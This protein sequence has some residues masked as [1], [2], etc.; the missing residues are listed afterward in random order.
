M[1]TTTLT[2]LAILKV[3]VD[4]GQDYLEYLR[5]FV[6]QVLVDNCT[7]RVSVESVT[8]EIGE[9]FGLSIPPR[10][11]EIVLKRICKSGLLKRDHNAYVVLGDLP[12][13]RLTLRQAEAQ[14]HIDSVLRGLCAFSHD[15]PN[16]VL[17]DE[18]AVAAVSAFLG[19]FDI[20]C[21]RAQLRGTAIPEVP[22]AN[23]RRILLVS[24]YVRHLQRSDPER[25]E[26]FLVL[27]K[28][29]MLAN[30]LTCPDLD[31]A[32]ASYGRLTFYL[33]TPLLIRYLGLEDGA[34]KT[35]VQELLDLIRSL[36]GKVAAFSHTVDEVRSVV[37]GSAQYLEIG[38]GR[39]SSIVL[40]A[41]KRGTSRSDLLLLANTVEERLQRLGVEIRTTPAYG[42]AFQID[43]TAFE[44]VL[45]RE[46]LYVNQRAKE[47]DIN[48]RAEHL[49]LERRQGDGFAREL[50][51]GP[52]NEQRAASEG[53]E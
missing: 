38:E 30:A 53:G 42:K 33:D 34:R 18:Q 35:A 41:R 43:E 29:N 37:R 17:D 5:P 51:G 10:T 12:D 19:T 7:L 39:P 50:A 11:V 3:N 23:G 21:L 49:R 20:S 24:D 1:T 8:G 26:S 25:F 14:R 15:T 52:R 2:S 9:Q 22:G 27:V 32:P 47:Y 28:G 16:P 48:S 4:R 45:D 40:E 36:D 6:L 46:L 31:K 13:P 44:K